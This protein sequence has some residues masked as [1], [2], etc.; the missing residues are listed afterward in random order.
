MKKKRKKHEI[1]RMSFDEV[2]ETSGIKIERKGREILISSSDSRKQK[3]KSIAEREASENTFKE[4]INQLIKEAIEYSLKL[5]PFHAL[6]TISLK[7]GFIDLEEYSESTFEGREWFVEYALSLF[8]SNE[9][10]DENRTN[11]EQDEV[12]FMK[13]IER[14]FS[15]IR[16]YYATEDRNKDHN[17]TDIILRYNSITDNLFIRG[18]SYIEHHFELIEEIYAAHDSFFKKHF[19]VVSR[20]FI[21]VVRNIIEQ[22]NDNYK[23]FVMLL[24]K[25]NEAKDDCLDDVFGDFENPFLVNPSNEIERTI[26]KLLSSSFGDNKAFLE[27]EHSPG[28]PINESI[29]YKR[30][31]IFY[32]D[33]FFCFSPQILIRNIGNILEGLIQETDDGY[34]QSKY[35]SARGKYLENKSLE[36]FSKLLPDAQIY[37]ELYYTINDGGEVKRCETDCLIVYDDNIFIIEAKAGKF[38]SSARRGSVK[39]IKKGSEKLISNAYDQALRAKNYIVNYDNPTFYNKNKSIAISFNERDNIRNIFLINVTLQNISNLSTKLHSLK[40]IGLL[41]GSE[42]PWSV[43]VNDLRVIS[44]LIDSPSIFILYLQRRIKANNFPAFSTHD[45]LDY[46]MYFFKHGLYLNDKVVKGSS[47]IIPIGYTEELDRYYNFIYGKVSSGDKPHYNISKEYLEFIKSIESTAKAHRT[48]ITTTLLG[49]DSKT[50]RDFIKAL[51]NNIAKT[52]LDNLDHSFTMHFRELSLG[53]TVSNCKI[54]NEKFWKKYH[55]YCRTVKYKHKY[56]DWI[57]LAVQKGEQNEIITTFELYSF[58]WTRDKY[59]EEQTIGF[60]ESKRNVAISEKGKV[61]RNDKC[62]CNSGKKFK[63]CCGR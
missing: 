26:Y 32:K 53:L 11:S 61:G 57:L 33:C 34:Y 9:L 22:I 28:W 6:A 13:L 58:N 45:E 31:L 50:Q 24:G 52:E 60:N 46:L 43:F 18:D 5:D 10:I 27:L 41:E 20:D 55:H 4:E 29:V 23:K 21:G 1:N 36:Y 37:N 62:P 39:K 30:P 48:K 47:T 2:H 15:L 12:S 7:N 19:N 16:I 25:F 35:Q 42:W 56:N 49:F 3:I 59:W 51:F 14:I 40:D 38:P 54:L 8:L 44:E 17:E 63:K